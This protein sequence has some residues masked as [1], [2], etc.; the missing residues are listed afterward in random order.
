MLLQSI[1]TQA[2]RASD[3]W[4]HPQCSEVRVDVDEPYATIH[5]W[6][7]KRNIPTLLADMRN[8]KIHKNNP[9]RQPLEKIETIARIWGVYDD[10]WSLIVCNNPKEV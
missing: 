10:M 4:R 9:F 1:T 6:D 5:L 3:P 8:T 2:D 7:E